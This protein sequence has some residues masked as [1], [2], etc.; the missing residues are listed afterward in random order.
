M[1]RSCITFVLLFTSTSAAA[2]GVTVFAAASL[3]DAVTDVSNAYYET[4]GPR[5]RIS[6]AASSMLARQIEAG[7][8]ADIFVSASED[9]MDYLE[10]REL[11]DSKSRQSPI[12]NRLVLISTEHTT[13]HGGN[14]ELLPSWVGDGRLV[15][16]DPAH[17]PAGLYAKHALQSMGLWKS[18]ESRLALS[19][20]VRAA[21]SLVDL[22][23][24]RYG[25]VYATDARLSSRARTI[26][27]FPKTSHETINYSFALVTNAQ[28]AH[29]FF[30]FL[31]SKTA[32]QIYEHHGFVTR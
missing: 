22:G 4:G 6:F 19:D 3:T 23:E 24:A 5:M 26:A 10:A 31:T 18:I 2:G 25:I 17:V 14:M 20:N 7:A 12:G 13:S 8:P 32:I 1:I 28:H 16:G 9:W 27:I 11:V 29:A 21:L 30:D 15:I